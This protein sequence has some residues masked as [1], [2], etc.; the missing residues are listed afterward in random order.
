MTGGPIFVATSVMQVVRRQNATKR[1]DVMA[2]EAGALQ[3]LGKVIPSIYYDLIARVCSG[4]P[5]LA[6]LLWERIDAFGELTWV[7][8]TL[9]V[10]AGY[11]AGLL[12]TPLSRLWLPLELL[13]LKILR[14][15][16]DDWRRGLPRNDE[17]AARDQQAGATLAKM[18]AEATLCQN[19]FCAF[20]LLILLNY[21]GTFL[22][23]A[24]GKWVMGLILG[25]AAIFRTT[26]YLGRQ[27]NL[28]EIVVHNPTVARA[29][30]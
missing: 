18:Q 24:A 22:V 28:Y 21:T 2:E 14:I 10:G 19:L 30:R 29:A 16:I 8:L 12:L 25:L 4:I 20:V 15:P 17:I 6:I 5:F 11:V 9:L 26:V 7:K 13:L 1:E 23:P 3:E 27:N